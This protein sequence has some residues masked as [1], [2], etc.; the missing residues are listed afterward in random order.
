MQ[1]DNSTLILPTGVSICS[2]S[3]RDVGNV[4]YI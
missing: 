3:K 1:K 4:K 2:V